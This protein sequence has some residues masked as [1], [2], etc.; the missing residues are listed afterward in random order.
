M[1][2]SR[3]EPGAAVRPPLS[4]K[5]P[6]PLRVGGGRGPNRPV[7]GG[8]F[9]EVGERSGTPL[10]WVCE[11]GVPLV[12]KGG[13]RRGGVG[14]QRGVLSSGVFIPL[15]PPTVQFLGCCPPAQ[16]RTA[17]P[18][19][20]PWPPA[21][22]AQRSPKLRS[23]SRSVGPGEPSCVGSGLRA[24]GRDGDPPHQR[25]HPQP[26]GIRGCVALSL[27]PL[28]CTEHRDAGGQPAPGE[29]RLR[30]RVQRLQ[31]HQGQPPLRPLRVRCCRE[32]GEDSDS[33][34][35]Q[36]GA[37]HPHQAGATE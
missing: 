3:S 19:A 27:P 2:V 26:R 24:V 33:S 32:G 7:L 29:L 6:P 13:D 25:P 5:Q 37:A 11:P 15:L 12:G 1:G 23:S 35:R 8:S 16:P 36:W 34:G 22:M 14:G 4:W 10:S 20:P 21:R 17:S 30:H 9:G 31:L 28:R 18:A